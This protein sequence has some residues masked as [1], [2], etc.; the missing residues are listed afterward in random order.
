[1]KYNNT[2]VL[3]NIPEIHKELSLRDNLMCGGGII[4]HPRLLGYDLNFVKINKGAKRCIETRWNTRVI[5][6]WNSSL[7]KHLEEGGMYGVQINNSLVD[8]KYL[9]VID[10]DNREF[11]DKV[12]NQ[13]PK[14]FTTSS[15]SKKNCLHL[16]F[17]TDKIEKKFA[18][19]NEEGKTLADVLGEHGQIVAPGSFHPGGSTYRV[20]NDMPITFIPYD[21]VLKILKPY[22][23]KIDKVVAAAPRISYGSNSFYNEV[24]SK[25]NVIDVLNK[26]GI[27]TQNSR[28]NCPF[29]DSESHECLSF[30]E[31][32]WNCWHC[33][34]SGNLFTLVK[35]V[36]NLDTLDT[37]EKLAELTG[38]EDE[39]KEY[40][41]EY[42][43]VGG[44]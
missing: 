7:V 1:M 6:H 22:M 26:L 42:M 28:T 8:G 41:S 39:L 25:I 20:V 21:E 2:A 18:I 27:D 44:N 16:W 37:F 13:F 35:E 33:G 19:L 9:L 15:G 29:H 10:F 31:K 4:I 40:Q 30:T 24:R 32:V 11:Q 23:K 43:K 38:L 36:Y 5:R 34:K 12:I 17:S 3:R 14:T